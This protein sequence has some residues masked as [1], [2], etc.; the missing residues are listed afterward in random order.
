[1]VKKPSYLESMKVCQIQLD[2]T[3]LKGKNP[4]GKARLDM[5][6]ALDRVRFTVLPLLHKKAEDKGGFYCRPKINVFKGETR[7]AE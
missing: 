2:K 4:Q 5:T 1:M 3:G 7:G 6:S